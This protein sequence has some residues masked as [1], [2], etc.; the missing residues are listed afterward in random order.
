MGILES[1]DKARPTTSNRR[2]LHAAHV[3]EYVAETTS[4]VTDQRNFNIIFKQKEFML[5]NNVILVCLNV[6][7]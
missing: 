2:W 5:N 1:G 3:L 7:T 4:S 6:S